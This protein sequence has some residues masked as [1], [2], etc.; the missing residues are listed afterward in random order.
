M[1]AKLGCFRSSQREDIN[2]QMLG[3]DEHHKI[4]EGLVNRTLQ[5]R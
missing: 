5:R 1:V 2:Q 4:Y 3:L